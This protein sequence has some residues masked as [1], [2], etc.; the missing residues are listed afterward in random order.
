MI[1]AARA[2]AVADDGLRALRGEGD[3]LLAPW[4]DAA[5]GDAVLVHALDGAPSYWLVPM[6][7]R[8]RAVGFARVGAD[9]QLIAIGVTCRSA[10]ALDACPADVT[11][12]SADEALER[13]RAQ[14][15]LAVGEVPGAV[16]YVHDGPVGR[17][18]WLVET[19]RGG[20][21]CRWFFVTPAGHYDRPAGRL[22]GGTGVE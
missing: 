1:T 18:A 6:V 7:V 13:V 17:E 14:G 2:R 10:Q 8:G 3:A 22:A 4:P 9:A 15:H 19:R 21:A 16:R 12:L 5:M 20:A 11:G